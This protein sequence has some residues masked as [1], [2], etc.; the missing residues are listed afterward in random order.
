M[1]AQD[2][3]HQVE[4]AQDAHHGDTFHLAGGLE[5][6]LRDSKEKDKLVTYQKKRAL[7]ED[8]EIIVTYAVVKPL[9]VMVKQMATPIALIAVLCELVNSSFA[10][11]AFEL[12][13]LLDLVQELGILIP[14]SLIIHQWVCRVTNRAFVS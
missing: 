1:E 2:Q 14:Y 7:Y 4:Q 12:G 13:L 3:H 9:A 8:I 6:I 10:G 5:T 11:V